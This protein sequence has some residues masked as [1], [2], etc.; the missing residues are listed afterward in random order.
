MIGEIADEVVMIGETADE[1]EEVR[2]RSSSWAMREGPELL[3]LE[4][5][6]ARVGREP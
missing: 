2:R 1:R 3:R 6:M 5:C 4:S